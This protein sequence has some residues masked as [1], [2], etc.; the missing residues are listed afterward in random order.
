MKTSLSVLASSVLLALGSTAQAESLAEIYELAL[1]NDPTFQAAQATYR[2]GQEAIVS[3]RKNLLPGIAETATAGYSLGAGKSRSRLDGGDLEKSRTAEGRK[4]FNVSGLS[5]RFN[6][7]NW[8]DFQAAGHDV[9]RAEAQFAL[10]QQ[11]L[12][13]RVV[14]SYLDVLRAK[15]ALDIA[16][17][18]E[19]ESERRLQNAKERFA[20]GLVSITDVHQ[21]QA[22]YDNAVVAV[23]QAEGEYGIRFEALEI[24]TGQRHYEVS[25]LKDD[26]PIETPEPADR[27][28]WVDFALENNN[29]LKVAKL[30]KESSVASAEGTKLNYTPTVSVNVGGY[31]YT[32]TPGT[33]VDFGAGPQPIPARESA[34]YR[35]ANVSISVPIFTWGLNASQRRV[36]A[37]QQ[38]QAQE[39]YVNARRTIVQGTR[40]AF[41]TA[42]TNAARV[43]ALQ[44]AVTSAQSAYEAT[45]A[46]YEVGTQNILDVLSEQ[47]RLFQAQQNYTNARYD[48]INSLLGLKL[49]AGQLSPEDIYTL[50]DWLDEQA[51]I[52]KE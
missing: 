25:P 47:N 1:Q 13:T 11:N 16:R 32:D 42:K 27:E 33:T 34:S 10:D 18:N 31:N 49:E 23:L 19:R 29:N 21:A 14:Q 20:V 24:L 36:A 17:S 41:L 6:V 51:N 28:E 37:Q 39:N 43:K 35:D 5:Y 46:G 40:S 22:T 7:R 48:Y 38:V 26:F 3:P 4:T 12:I 45:Q 50:N 30:T 44:S 52:R 15:E 8:F 2:I 9:E